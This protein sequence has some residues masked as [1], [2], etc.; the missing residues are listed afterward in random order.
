MKP[1]MV[2][3]FVSCF[4]VCAAPAFSQQAASSS[5]ATTQ[6]SAPR[7]PGA[8][9]NAIPSYPDSPAGLDQLIKDMLKLQKSG[10]AKALAPYVQS[11]IL[12][13][14]S[15]WFASTFGDQM[16]RELRDSYERVQMELALSF[17]DLLAQLRAKHLTNP[18]A[19][20]FSESCDPLAS[21]DEYAVLRRRTNSQ[22]LYDV[23][24]ANGSEV[25]LLH[26]FAY[27][28]GAFRYISSF[29][30]NP[31]SQ[32]ASQFPSQS[33]DKEQKVPGNVMAAKLVYSAP[34]TYPY[35][36]KANGV[37]GKVV[38]HAIIGENGAVCSLHVIQGPPILAQA[39][40]NAVS[41][42]RYSPTT[43]NGQPVAVDTT[44]TVIFQLR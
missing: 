42:W 27:V 44:I 9:A 11:L 22:P 21:D 32:G 12:P 26:Y 17:P 3:S 35:D 14:P 39:A 20:R 15:A 5:S 7:Q 36:A 41:Q 28:D 30:V 43:L 4:L 2:L 29:T 19:V 23:R 18:N 8:S 25:G 10:D 38:L 34:P 37:Q 33:Q 13:D 24:F 16:G 31:Q 40:I 1:R 6:L